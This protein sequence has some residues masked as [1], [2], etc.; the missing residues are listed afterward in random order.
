M[1]LNEVVYSTKIT[2]QDVLDNAPD[3]IKEK[4]EAL[5]EEEQKEFA[6]KNYHSAKSG[7]EFGL[8]D[9]MSDVISTINYN[10]E[11]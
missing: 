8:A 6:K 7:F 9:P 4:F 5:S 11:F 2:L 1:H 10:F 3:E